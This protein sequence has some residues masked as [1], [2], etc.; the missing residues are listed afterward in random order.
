MNNGFHATFPD[1][2]DNK[3]HIQRPTIICEIY[4]WL[5]K[6]GIIKNLIE[7]HH[8][9]SNRNSFDY[10]EDNSQDNNE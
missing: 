8:R 5:M 7:L 2:S 3:R 6:C 9:S 4:M 10:Y 1:V